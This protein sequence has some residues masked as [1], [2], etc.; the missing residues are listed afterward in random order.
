M[1]DKITLTNLVNLQN[2]TTAVNAINANNAAITTA[3]DN[4]LSRDGTQPN[5]MGASL[6][7]NSNQILN[8]PQPLTASSPARLQDLATLN[9]D[10][11]VSGIPSGGTTGQTL[12]K[13][14]NLDFA[15]SWASQSAGIQA[16]TNITV[17][18]SSPATLATVANPTF[19]TKVI[20]P[21]INNGGDLA[22]PNATDT[23]VARATT[24]TLTNKTFDTAGTGNVFRIAG[25]G[26]SAN[27]GT[28]SNVLATAPTISAP[29]V[30]GHPTIEG[31][32]STGATGTGSLVFATSP[33]LVTPNL[34]TPSAGVLTNTTGLPLATGVTG[35]LSINNLNSGTA[36][37]NTTFWRGDAVWAAP[38]AG[39]MIALETIT[40][41]G[42]AS[43][44]SAVSWSGYSSIEFILYSVVASSATI[45][46]M[47]VHS[48]GSYQATNY[49]V[50]NNANG[51]AASTWAG[52]TSTTTYIPIGAAITANATSTGVNARITLSNP[53]DTT[54]DKS[55]YG[56]GLAISG[57]TTYWFTV[58]GFWN[59][60]TTAID[61]CKFLL[62]GGGTLN[63]GFI[64]IYG[65][66]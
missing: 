57:T 2:E 22:V 8:L 10:G 23:L 20:T 39:T 64:R 11:T 1:T 62:S 36:A 58:G 24:D 14:S 55:V 48:N 38:P 29:V 32:T 19:S 9:G 16:G 47:Q 59:G 46:G 53:A 5:T 50:S 13:S 45:L 34:G 51:T 17:T 25:T 31:V 41:A 60:G 3:M 56:H 15:T 30:S 35:N 49:V 44:A 12:V 40:L 66:V 21:L 54:L 52:G 43:Y 61:G 42:A 7:M 6:D 18:G 37:A 65:I 28:G 4:T 33:T 26:I 27:T 63:S